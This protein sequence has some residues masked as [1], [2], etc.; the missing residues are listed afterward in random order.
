MGGKAVA[1]SELVRCQEA[2]GEGEGEALES[3]SL[4]LSPSPEHLSG[5]DCLITDVK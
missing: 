2:G 1:V 5:D 4:P 3:P